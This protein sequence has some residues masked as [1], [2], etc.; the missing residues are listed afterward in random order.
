[1]CLSRNY[2]PHHAKVELDL[3]GFDGETLAFVEVRT[4]EL[5]SGKTTLPELSIWKTQSV[6]PY[7]HYFLRERHIGE[8]PM[9]FDVVTI[10]NAP[11][12]LPLVRLHKDA[13]SPRV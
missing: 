10:D 1:M 8:C 9:R 6:D 12:R 5:T 2:E 11:G 7:R 13:L 4:R 3:A